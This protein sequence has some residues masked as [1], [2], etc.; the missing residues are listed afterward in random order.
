MST[1]PRHSRRLRRL[2]DRRRRRRRSGDLTVSARRLRKGIRAP[3]RVR[4]MSPTDRTRSCGE[5]PRPR[6][7]GHE[8]AVE[9][10]LGRASP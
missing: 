8:S 5:H 6:S 3:V 10:Y 1:S 2:D 9:L 7:T 4:A